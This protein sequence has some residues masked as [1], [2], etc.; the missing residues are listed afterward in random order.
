MD[1]A[2]CTSKLLRLPPELLLSIRGF[3][4]EF[5]ISRL[6]R[7]NRHLYGQLDGEFFF[8]RSA[9]T[10]ANSALLLAAEH[11]HMRAVLRA[12]S[13]GA[14]VNASHQLSKYTPL[15]VA[16]ECG[17]TDIVTYLLAQT[18][19]NV[20]AVAN[21]G[22]TAL[23]YAARHGHTDI[24]EK[25]LASPNLQVNLRDH[26]DWTPLIWAVKKGHD[27]IVQLLE[28]IVPCYEKEF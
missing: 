7:V 23:H 15:V 4:D 19:I 28:P 5:D 24:V 10:P 26:Y 12:I 21:H 20:N 22:Q 9:K 17:H 18:S 13:E 2:R 27:A 3:L 8:D 1:S 14:D 6:C 25:L 16:A 11:N